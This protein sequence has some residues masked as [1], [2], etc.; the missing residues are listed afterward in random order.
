MK[1]YEEYKPKEKG[2]SDFYSWNLYRWL[3]KQSKLPEW[4]QK[5]RIYKSE[6]GTVFIGARYDNVHDGVTGTRLRHLCS[7]SGV[8]RFPEVGLWVGSG[9]WQDI[10]DEFY[11]EYERVGVC[12]IHGD[13]AHEF[14]VFGNARQCDYCGK[15]ERKV[16]RMI[17]QVEWVDA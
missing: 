17:E 16:V 3:R 5:T 7:G 2:K 11:A 9:Q 15:V 14:T 8:G 4:R 1:H 13:L 6:D 10:T 12:A